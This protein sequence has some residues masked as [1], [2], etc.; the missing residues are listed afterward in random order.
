MKSFE[1]ILKKVV[2]VLSQRPEVLAV[3]L[4]GSQ[5]KGEAREDSDIDIAIMVDPVFKTGDYNSY[6]IQ[7]DLESRVAPLSE[8]KIEVVVLDNAKLPLGYRACFDGRLLF[9]RDGLKRFA[10][11][12]KIRNLFEDLKDFFDLR[13]AYNF[14]NARKHQ[15]VKSFSFRQ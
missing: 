3:Y 8:K 15:P 13:L 12:E 7:F 11:E 10:E 9:S 2:A 6:Q 1:V 4:F 5:A 14:L